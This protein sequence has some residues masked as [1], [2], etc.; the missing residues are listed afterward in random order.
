MEVDVDLV[1]GDGDAQFL[2]MLTQAANVPDSDLDNRYYFMNSYQV[3][4]DLEGAYWHLEATIT[5]E[6]TGTDLDYTYVI[7]FEYGAPDPDDAVINN[8]V[9]EEEEVVD[10][11]GGTTP[12]DDDEDDEEE[13]ADDEESSKLPWYKDKQVIGI[14]IVAVVV[15]VA[16]IV[17]V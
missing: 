11:G 4:D 15:I 14:I 7:Q 6:F 10:G 8:V 2:T 12:A 16:I 1:F 17:L 5:Y 3:A 13:P 9:A